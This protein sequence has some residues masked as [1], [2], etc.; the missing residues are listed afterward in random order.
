MQSLD[1]DSPYDWNDLDRAIHALNRSKSALP[2]AF[3]QLAE[4]ELRALM[5]YHPELEGTEFQI[6]N[7]SPFNFVRFK[8]EEGEV[9]ALFSS[10]ARA[11]EALKKGDVPDNTFCVAAMPARQM[12]EVLGAMNMRVVVNRSCATGAMTLPADLMRDL[13]SGKVLEPLSMKTGKT[14]ERA[15]N[16]IDPADYPTDL[17]QPLF[18]VL[19][20]DRKFRAAWVLRDPEPTLDGGVHYAFLVLMDPRDEVLAHDFNLVLQSA[21]KKP[22]DSSFSFMDETD[23]ACIESILK[24]AAPFYRAPDFEF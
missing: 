15:L 23:E 10:E 20:A 24:Q 12:L 5:P 6:Q 1:V 21:C 19:R 3:R 11:E 18:E 22:D 4:G 9:V 8:D 2:E 7:G 16:L 17:L 13:A 14:R